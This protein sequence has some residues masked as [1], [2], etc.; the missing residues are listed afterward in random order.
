M[1]LDVCW[2]RRRLECQG[3]IDAILLERVLLDRRPQL[4]ITRAPIDFAKYARLMSSV[5]MIRPPL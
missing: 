3:L 1:P 5:L 2:N 4:K